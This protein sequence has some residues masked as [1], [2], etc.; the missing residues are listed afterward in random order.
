MTEIDELAALVRRA[1]AA[2]PAEEESVAFHPQEFLNAAMA[3]GE[4]DIAAKATL[5]FRRMG[6]PVSITPEVATR[7]KRIQAENAAEVHRRIDK[8][9]YTNQPLPLWVRNE[10]GVTY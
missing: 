6:R 4:I 8:A 5:A 3:A 10:L 7:A 1:E 2:P 9:N